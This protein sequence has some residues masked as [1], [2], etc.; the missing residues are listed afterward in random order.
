MPVSGRPINREDMLE[1]TRRMTLKRNCFSRIAGA[2]F[3]EEGEIDGT[4]N[5]HFGRLSAAERE[6]HLAIAKTIPFGEPGRELN[7][8]LFPKE[9]RQPG[10]LFQLLNGMK[11]SALKN[12]AL[13]DVFYEYAGSRYAEK[14]GAGHP[15]G[16]FLFYGDYDV[17]FKGT[18]RQRQW[19]SEEVYS[20]LIIAFA[21]VDS[22]YEPEDVCFGALYPAFRDRS[23]SPWE[24][25]VY[26]KADK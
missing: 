3:D 9:E 7:A 15:F 6:K 14:Y 8:C 21:P 20:F 22:G 17:P 11:E 13:L 19:E 24:A 10:S 25:N 26:L 16:C 23:S 1:L 18:D 5:R 4:F 12:D 2:Y